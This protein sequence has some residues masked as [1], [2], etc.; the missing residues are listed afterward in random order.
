MAKKSSFLTDIEKKLKNFPSTTEP[1]LVGEVESFGD[2][3][4]TVSGL[5]SIMANELVDL[6][7]GE[8][9]LALNLNEETVGVVALGDAAHITVG[10]PVYGTGRLLSVPVSNE[11]IGRVVDPLGTPLDGKGEFSIEGYEEMEKIAPG[12]MA[13]QS[14]SEP[15]QTGIKAIDAMIPIGRGQ[16]ELIIGDRGTGKSAVALGT[17]LNQHDQ[18]VICVY[19]AIGQKRSFLSQ[20]HSLLEERGAMKYTVMV[21][22]SASDTAAK[23]YLAPMAGTAIAEHFLKQGKDVLVIYDDLS[24]HAQ[25]YREVSLLLRRPSGREAYP[26]DVFYLHSRLLER[27]CRL[28]PEHGGGSITALPIIETQANDVSAYIPTNVISITDGQIYLESDLFNA[29]VRPAINV[30]LSVSRVGSSAQIKAM[31]QVAGPMKLELAQYRDLEAFSQFSSDLDPA[32]KKQLARGERVAK[33]LNQ[34]WD[35]PLAVQ[36]QIVVIWAATRGYLDGIQVDHIR[37]WESG[38]IQHVHDTADDI[39]TSIVKEKKLLDETETALKK[40][41]EAY[42]ELHPEWHIA[43]EE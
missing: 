42:N 11:L 41:V 39:Y 15:L 20:T 28:N 29:G 3:V 24:K 9:G 25:A 30:G 4:V 18:D 5:D 21:V 40:V 16:R 26:G 23:Q 43:K 10:Q 2:G 27:A 34:G 38:F 17:I 12:V 14:V 19:V 35:T 7:R 31:K 1:R 36:E 13:R 8:L 32:T 22:A 33:I 37:E 6:G